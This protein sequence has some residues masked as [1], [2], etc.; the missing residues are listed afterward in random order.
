[1]PDVRQ[2]TTDA[3]ALPDNERATLAQRL[4]DSLAEMPGIEGDEE[5]ERELARRTE[6][7]HSGTAVIRDWSEVE[8]VIAN[9]RESRR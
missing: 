8:A 6:R 4:L 3:L 1:M 9:L 2:L 5:F 7:V